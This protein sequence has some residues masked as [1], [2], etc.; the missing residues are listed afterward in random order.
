M[1]GYWVGDSR[2]GSEGLLEIDAEPGDIIARGQKDYRNMR[3][4]APDW[5]QLQQD[6]TLSGLTGKAA[7]ISAFREQQAKVSQPA[8]LA[9]EEVPQEMCS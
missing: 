2:N 9:A 1:W 5:Y 4:S 8:P 7:A 3:H 6:G